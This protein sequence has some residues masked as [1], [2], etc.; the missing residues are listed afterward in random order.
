MPPKA[1]EQMAHLGLTSFNSLFEMLHYNRRHEYR[2]D[3]QLSFNSLFEMLRPGGK[4]FILHNHLYFQFS[5]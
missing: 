1:S 4:D 2:R 5:I 3:R